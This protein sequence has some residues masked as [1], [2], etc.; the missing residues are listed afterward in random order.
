MNIGLRARRADDEAVAR[1]IALQRAGSRGAAEAQFAAVLRQNSRHAEANNAM[2]ALASEAEKYDVA[3]S[4]FRN[5]LAAKPQEPRYLN[6]LGLAFNLS[7]K[8]EEGLPF[9]LAAL[10]RA[11][12]AYEIL[13]NV[14]RCYWQLGIAFEGIPYLEKATKEHPDRIEG[15][16]LLADAHLSAG[17]NEEAESIFRRALEL[18]PLN[19]G[20]LNGIANARKQTAERNV[21]PGIEKA[22]GASTDDAGA[23]RALHY[24][25]AKSYIDLKDPDSAFSHLTAAK[26]PK[27]IDREQEASRL[28]RLKVLYNPV[29]LKAREK[30]GVQDRTPVFIVG[31]PRSGTSLTEQIVSSHPQVFGAGEL[32]YLHNIAN[33]LLYSLPTLDLYARKVA[34]LTEAT[35]RQ[36]ADYYLKKIRVFSSD[37]TVIT[38]KMPHNFLHIGLIALILPEAR[39]IHCRRNPLDNCFSIYSNNFN[40]RHAYAHDLADL[41]WYYRQYESLMDHWRSVLPHMI[42]DVQYEELVDDLERQTRRILDFIGLPFDEACLD[43]QNNRRS[44]TTISRSQVRQ[45]M[46]RTSIERW[47]PYEKHLGPLIAALAE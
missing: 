4:F 23:S 33:Q 8:P 45:P 21:L 30:L 13:C 17:E 18:A 27:R 35:S 24:A 10:K 22:L 31:M 1:G 6:N 44:V 14:G 37:A 40:E 12:K 32:G 7:G 29:F 28:N 36:L 43:F 41:G 46:Y 34:G 38:D 25:A 26:S 42:L 2:G 19:P 3:I 11:P 16:L 47:R 20:A 39:I 9:L 5:A 15:L